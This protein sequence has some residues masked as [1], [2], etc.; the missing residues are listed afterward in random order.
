[1]TAVSARLRTLGEKA[2]SRWAED[3]EE[4]YETARNA[5]PALMDALDAAR[6]MWLLLDGDYT[7]NATENPNYGCRFR[8][9]DDALA[10]LVSVACPATKKE[11]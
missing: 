4:F 7:G 5:W 3:R 2:D 11:D 1:M 6:S 9:L 10:A 8:A